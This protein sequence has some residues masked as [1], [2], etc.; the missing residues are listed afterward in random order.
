M[1]TIRTQ[2]TSTKPRAK[3]VKGKVGIKVCNVNS[4]QRE[5]ETHI[6]TINMQQKTQSHR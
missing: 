4:H 5:G 3:V 2:E 1:I 6:L